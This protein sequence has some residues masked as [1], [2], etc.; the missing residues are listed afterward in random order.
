[1]KPLTDEAFEVALADMIKQVREQATQ[2]R[3]AVTL[4]TT[5]ADLWNRVPGRSSTI[6]GDMLSPSTYAFLYLRMGKEDSIK[7]MHLFVDEHIEGHPLLKF[8]SLSE[9]PHSGTID[10]FYQ[11]GSSNICLTFIFVIEASTSCAL[12]ETGVMRPVLA[13]KCT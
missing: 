5:F 2:I 9:C 7:D 1:M 11:F 8:S 6:S 4:A 10:Y 13:I 12:V 3:G